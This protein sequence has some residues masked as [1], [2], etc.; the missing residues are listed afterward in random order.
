MLSSLAYLF[1]AGLSLGYIFTRLHLPS[2]VGMLLAGILL[3]S[4][5]LNLLDES[6]L[7]ISIELR[8]IALVIILLRAGLALNLGDLKQVGRPAVLLCFVPACLEIGG[9]MLL[10]P[11]LL[12]VS[13]LEAAVIGAVVAAVSP[14]VIV[15]KMLGLMEQGRGTSKGIPQMIMAGG[16]IDDIFVIVLFT[17]FTTLATGGEVSGA[18]LLNIPFSILLGAGVGVVAGVLLSE[19]FKRAQMRDTIKLIVMISCSLLFLTLEAALKETIALSGLLAVMVMGI[20]MLWRYPTLA[21]RLSPKLNKVW[22]GAEVVLF[23]LVGASVNIEYAAAAGF[24]PA[25]LILLVLIFRMVGVWL[26]TTRTQLNSRERLFSMIAYTPK[27]TV[28]A[29]I[30]SI[31]LAMGLPCGEIVL[32][33]AVLSIIITAPLGAFGIDLTSRFLE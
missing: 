17:A 24:T 29:A 14:A 9:V 27:A 28:Q 2:L 30:G 11:A 15:P 8:Q 19:F 16:S 20:T 1:I 33:V 23:V 7:G 26:S 3:G 6:L 22:V 21:K 5:G 4:S 12:G 13:L 25:L 18:A 10:A 31:P 32:T